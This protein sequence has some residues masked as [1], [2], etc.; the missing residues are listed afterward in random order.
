MR[1]DADG[2]GVIAPIAAIKLTPPVLAEVE[3]EIADVLTRHCDGEWSAPNAARAIMRRL[4]L[5]APKLGYHK[6]VKR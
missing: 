5:V 4:K 3:R 2:V 6:A 1:T